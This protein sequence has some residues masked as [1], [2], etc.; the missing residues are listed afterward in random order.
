MAQTCAR[1]RES[2]ATR[3]PIDVAALLVWAFQHFDEA[4][5]EVGSAVGPAW[6]DDETS[7]GLDRAEL[8]AA[9]SIDPDA[10]AIVQ[11]VRALQGEARG[12]VIGAARA[13]TPPDWHGGSM[14]GWRRRASIF[15]VDE[16]RVRQA[17]EGAP[18]CLPALA[19][20]GK[21]ETIGKLWDAGRNA[22]ACEVVHVDRRDELHIARRRYRIWHECLVMLRSGLALRLVRWLPTGPVA[23]P[24]PWD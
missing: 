18:A 20:R 11:A 22:V 13:A 4:S 10:E 3:R 23:S 8:A 2:I 5:R 17:W 12:L 7:G 16:L 24:S 14:E 1:V 21:A 19:V 15:I 9:A 6:S